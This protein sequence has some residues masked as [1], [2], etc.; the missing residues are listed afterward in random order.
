VRGLKFFA[1]LGK[2][3]SINVA[4]FE[5]VWIEIYKYFIHTGLSSITSL[6]GARIKI[7]V[8]ENV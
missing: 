4:P 8:G 6:I 1:G 3:R 2:R 7:L 5:G